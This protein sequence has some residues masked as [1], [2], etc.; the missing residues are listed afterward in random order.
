MRWVYAG[1]AC[2]QGG[3]VNL[4]NQMKIIKKLSICILFFGVIMMIYSYATSNSMPFSN[5]GIWLVSAYMIVAALFTLCVLYFFSR[6][7]NK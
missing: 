4:I 6:L 2:D 7:N 1:G 5:A 3:E